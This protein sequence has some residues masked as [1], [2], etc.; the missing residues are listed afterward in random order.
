MLFVLNKFSQVRS[1]MTDNSGKCIVRIFDGEWT[2]TNS[3]N[4]Y[5]EVSFFFVRLVLFDPMETEICSL[6]V[7]AHRYI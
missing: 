2:T 1:E 4:M 7:S 6:V 5:N 3:P